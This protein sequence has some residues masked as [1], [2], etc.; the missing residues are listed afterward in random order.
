MRQ[1]SLATE[2]VAHSEKFCDVFFRAIGAQ[3]FRAKQPGARTSE[4]QLL[5]F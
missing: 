2:V 1:G 4:N 3:I 5:P